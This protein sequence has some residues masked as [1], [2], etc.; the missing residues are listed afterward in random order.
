MILHTVRLV[1]AQERRVRV[2][3]E[4]PGGCAACL[5]GRGCGAGLFV[6]LL[7]AQPAEITLARPDG[8]D[9]GAPM[10]LA[11]DERALGRQAVAV[12]AGAVIAFIGGVAL[13]TAAPWVSGDLAALAAGFGALATWLVFAHR[14]AAR[15]PLQPH[16]VNTAGAGQSRPGDGSGG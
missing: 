3:L 10:A 4:P 11:I 8:L 9:P 12:Y 7:P 14:R 5:A 16:L 1:T 2:R 13:A 15:H 6:R